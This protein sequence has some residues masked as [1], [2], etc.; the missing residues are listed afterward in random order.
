MV[1]QESCSFRSVSSTVLETRAVLP[2]HRSW[3]N[4]GGDFI[5]T[6]ISHLDVVGMGLNNTVVNTVGPGLEGK[7]G[8]QEP[9][10]KWMIPTNT[11]LERKRTEYATAPRISLP[12]SKECMEKLR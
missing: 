9:G 3:G 5:F 6:S 10:K 8:P 11:Q 7:E 4:F 12:S 2:T 1:K